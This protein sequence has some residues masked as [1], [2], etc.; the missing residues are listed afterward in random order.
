MMGENTP[1]V[2]PNMGKVV[3]FTN[4][5]DQDFEHAYGGQPF[6]ILAGQSQHMPFDL[7]DHLA[8]HLARKI[9]LRG[10][11]GKNIYDPNDKSGGS[12]SKIWGLEEEMAL[13]NKILGN[14]YQVERAKEETEVERLKREVSELNSFVRANV[15]SSKPESAPVEN[16]TMQI[17]SSGLDDYETKADVIAKMN[18]LGIKFDARQNKDKLVEQLNKSL[19]DSNV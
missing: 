5:D 17:K 9:L 13:K 12:G 3:I 8:T 19:Q 6:T 7:A 16:P 2:S 18:E 14:T 11:S 1:R 10:D 15:P 4:I